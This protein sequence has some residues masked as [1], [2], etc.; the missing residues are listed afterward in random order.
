[1]HHVSDMARKPTGT[2]DDVAATIMRRVKRKPGQV[3][4]PIDFVDLGNR[5]VVDKNLQRLTKAGELRRIDRG[6]YDRPTHNPLTA[7]PSV[8]DYREVISAVMRRDQARMIVDGMTAAND[9]GLTTAVPAKIEVLVDARLKPIRL[10][11]QEITF[12]HAAPSRLYWAGRPAM[13]IVQALHWLKDIIERS[14]EERTQARTVIERILAD[15]RHGAKLRKDLRD[16][17][18]TLPIWMQDFLRSIL[19]PEKV[20]A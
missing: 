13:R 11:N 12:K 1:M 15:T 14:D 19:S 10:G 6:L 3:W 20:A 8:P 5:E 17:L 7:K 18:S 4:T 2:S 16:G 9:L